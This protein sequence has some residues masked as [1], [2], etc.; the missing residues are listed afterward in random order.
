MDSDPEPLFIHLIFA[1]LLVVLNGFFVATEYALMNVRSS[2]IDVLASEGNRRAKIAANMIGNLS[3]YISTC[4]MGITMSSIGLGWLAGPIIVARL[5]PFLQELSI[6]TSMASFIGFMIAFAIITACH[7]II[8]QQI[9][10]ITAIQKSE[11]MTLWSAA[12]LSLYY[13]LTLPLIWLLNKVSKWIL[14][15]TGIK[16]VIEQEAHT[17]EEIKVLVK[18]SHKQGHIENSELL[19]VDNIF[20]FK[21][22]VGREVMIPRTDVA[23][24]YTNLSFEENLHITSQEMHTRYP[25]GDPDKD[26]I[27]G[28]VHIKDLLQNMTNGRSNIRSIIRPLLSVHDYMPISEILKQM[29]QKR[30]EIALLIDEYGGTSGLVTMED[31]L[32][33]L[34]GEIYDEFDQDRPVIEKKDSHTHSVDGLMHIDEFNDFFGLDIQT[35]D[36]DTIGGWMYA[37][38][39]SQPTQNKS[40]L[41]DNLQMIIDE[42]DHHR[43]ARITVKKPSEQQEKIPIA[44]SV[45]AFS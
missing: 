3:A 2:R 15:S 26:N 27:I 17:E 38:V 42:V 30:T 12:P 43:I 36:Y 37:Q 6:P 9:P 10:K 8:S 44:N 24:L 20:D 16:P 29:Q 25:V 11:Q 40:V 19:L 33:E 41:Y 14:K 4:R 5:A 23:C 45:E 22:T 1:L 18:E 13:K 32:E 21:E 31:I 28:F 39:N 34:V 35:D 7:Y